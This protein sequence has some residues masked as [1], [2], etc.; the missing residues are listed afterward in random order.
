MPAWRLYNYSR[1]VLNRR[2][3]PDRVLS[4]VL[5]SCLRDEHKRKGGVTGI[6]QQLLSSSVYK[7]EEATERGHMT[8]VGNG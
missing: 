1:P 8:R 5:G 3:G 7:E 2:A 6:G 4:R